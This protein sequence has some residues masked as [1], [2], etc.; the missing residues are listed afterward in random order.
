M[1]LGT[2]PKPGIAQ[3]DLSPCWE[4]RGCKEMG[5]SARTEKGTPCWRL[6]NASNKGLHGL[7]Y[8][9]TLYA[10]LICQ[11]FKMHGEADAKGWGHFVFDQIYRHLE[12]IRPVTTE[13]AQRLLHI[14]DNLPEGLLTT[15]ENFKITYMNHTAAKITGIKAAD[16][17]GMPCKE[18]L[19]SQDCDTA[20]ALKRA[21]QG[22]GD[23]ETG[24]IVMASAEGREI[25][26]VCSTSVLKDPYGNI[27]GC[28]EVFSDISERK[29]L[30]DD[31]K[32]SESKYRRIFEGSKDLIFI[33]AKDG[34]IEDVNQAG[35][36]LLGY[37]SKEAFL[38][39]ASIE[40]IYKNS[41]H[42]RVFQKQI[43]RDGFVKDFDA[44]LEKK[45]GM[46]LHC[47]LSGNGI[48]GEGGSIIG[49]EGIAKDITARMDAIRAFRQRHQELWVLN[50]V[51]LAMNKTQD[52]D[53]VLMTALQK[54]LKALGLKSGAIFLIDYDKLD[55]ILRAEQGLGSLGQHKTYKILFDDELL[56]RS[57]LKKDFTLVPEPIFPPFMATL[58]E[59]S[60][61]KSNRLTC[62]LITAKNKATGFLALEV[63]KGIDILTGHA[64]HL[65]GSLGNFLG[66]AV[67][68]ASLGQTIQMHREEL[69]GLTAKL[70]QSQELERK[71]IARELHDEAGQVLTGIN[72]TLEAIE[73]SISKEPAHIK[74]L[75]SDVKH[76]LNR[77]YQEMRRISYRLHPALLT[78]LGLEPAI[79]AYIT[80]ISKHCDL[81]IHFRVMGFDERVD[82]EIETVLYR[83]SQEVLTNTIKHAKAEYF[84]LSIIKSYP[85]IIFN[86]EDDGVGFEPGDT[87]YQS[88]KLGLLSMRERASMLGGTFS[89]RT[90]PGQGTRIRIEI[91]VGE[92]CDEK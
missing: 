81:D 42:W 63:P 55:F 87:Q 91:P 74:A 80:Q 89:L 47:L 29:R 56:M 28:V 35:L 2:P 70:F 65:L 31:L 58:K 44:V 23:V 64:Y 69:K 13:S 33:A 92:E 57:L 50:S 85:S 72:F 3:Q 11:V 78:D 1:G 90:S 14:L 83:L 8:P 7:S 73:K 6:K 41:M 67:E 24:E 82:P 75:V 19:R 48:L 16:A 49:Y 76:Q 5:C 40:Q 68:N 18:V 59:G 4:I 66:G 46:G 62:F 9:E 43:N 38:S 10:C 71:R 26:L 45:D 61:R 15:D 53:T 17:V 22:S 12:E 30:E 60:I 52:L 77:N 37:D 86:A 79:E 39:L 88:Q 20:C 25:P 27:V 54:A 32:F 84:S 34:T 21:G 36:D 51:A